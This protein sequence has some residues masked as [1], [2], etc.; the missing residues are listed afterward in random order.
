[1]FQTVYLCL[2]TGRMYF[3]LSPPTS[4]L[5]NIIL[6]Y[7][8]K[9]NWGCT[10]INNKLIESNDLWVRKRSI[11]QTRAWS[12]KK[13]R[14]KTHLLSLSCALQRL[15]HLAF[16]Q[17]WVKSSK[18]CARA[19]RVRMTSGGKTNENIIQINEFCITKVFLRQW[20]AWIFFTC[21]FLKLPEIDR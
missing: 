15:H 5:N 9:L 1:M 2:V 3:Y 6:F 18:Y 10:I 12:A 8:L 20:Q 14:S 16:I 11:L 19:A 4:N 13:R 21:H 7:F 17:Y